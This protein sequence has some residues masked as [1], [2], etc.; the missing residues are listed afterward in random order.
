MITKELKIDDVIYGMRGETPIHIFTIERIDQKFA[1]AGSGFV[2]YK[3]YD[4]LGISVKS[5]VTFEKFTSFVHFTNAIV[6]QESEMHK[7]YLAYKARKFLGSFDWFSL[8][9]DV[10]INIKGKVKKYQHQ[11][12]HHVRSGVSDVQQKNC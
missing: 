6:A 2:F 11:H 8:S 1:Y 5:S 10:L 7:K 3:I 4:D 12:K 9:D